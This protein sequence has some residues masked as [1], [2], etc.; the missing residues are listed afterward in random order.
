M[1]SSGTRSTTRNGPAPTG[2]V[3]KA[4]RSCAASGAVISA[5]LSGDV[6]GWRDT[7]ARQFVT[8]A[9][10]WLAG[11]P[12]ENVVDKHLGYVPGAGGG[13]GAPSQENN[14][15]STQQDMQPTEHPE[16]GHERA[17]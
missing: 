6:V 17:N 2:C 10:R 3:A 16:V 14:E 9:E 4:S 1:W 5:H 12:L 13:T 11:Q 7:L 15:A 8:N